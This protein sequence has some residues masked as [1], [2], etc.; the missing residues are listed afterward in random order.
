MANNN[1]V[2][3]PVDRSDPSISLLKEPKDDAPNEGRIKEPKPTKEKSPTKF[4]KANLVRD[5]LLLVSII[6]GLLL[7]SSGSGEPKKK[8][9]VDDETD[10]I[11][12]LTEMLQNLA[13]EAAGL[14][15]KDQCSLFLHTGSIPNTGLGYFAG[16]NYTIGEIIL[17]DYHTMPVHVS[18]DENGNSNKIYAIPSALVLK[19]HPILFNIEGVLYY[20]NENDAA[21]KLQLRVSKAIKEGDELF[22]EYDPILHDNSIFN[23]IPTDSHYN[24]TKEIVAD[25]L[26]SVTD[27][28]ERS[29]RVTCRMIP[30]MRF[31]KQTVARYDPM[32]ATLLPESNTRANQYRKLHP[33][34]ATIRNSTLL[35][36]QQMGVCVDDIMPAPNSD[37]TTEGDAGEGQRIVAVAQ[38][39]FTRGKVV[40]TQPLHIMQSLL[41]QTCAL[42]QECKPVSMQHNCFMN[43][44]LT[45]ILFCP[46]GPKILRGAENDNVTTNSDGQLVNVEYRWSLHRGVTEHFHMR[47]DFKNSTSIMAWDVIALRDIAKDETVRDHKFSLH[48]RTDR[49]HSHSSHSR[50]QIL[51]NIYFRACHS[52]S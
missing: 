17:E 45:S 16:R 38:R 6:G 8:S 11:Q 51:I 4:G 47:D 52:Y 22:V 42:E 2:Q 1:P 20:H 32:V 14:R 12:S 41:S 43:E 13:K 27:Q 28:A 48:E 40:S 15:R 49:N 26:R 31:V 29:G 35:Q 36:L 10:H 5:I 33:S 23:H 7:L 39:N 46:L 18:E 24:R 34:V 37:D 30:V 9:E 50:S 44:N 3:P 25:A 21:P 19:H